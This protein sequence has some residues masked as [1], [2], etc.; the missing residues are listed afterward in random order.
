MFS[1]RSAVICEFFCRS[2]PAAALRGFGVV[3]LPSEAS[4][5]LSSTKPDSGMYTSPRTSSSGSGRSPFGSCMRVE[6][7]LIVF[8]FVVTSSPRRPSPRVAPRTS[9]PSS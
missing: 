9:L 1:G 3:F 2:E 6:I 4:R 7:A 5:S 8:R